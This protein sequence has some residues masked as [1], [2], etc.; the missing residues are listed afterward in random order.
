MKLLSL[1]ADKL[2]ISLS[3]LCVL[4][5]LALPLLLVIV[6]SLAVLPMAQESFHFWMVM[7]VLPT[8]IYALTLGC[9]KHRNYTVVSYGLAGLA[10]LLAAALFGEHLLGEMGEK[11]LTTVGATIIAV[12]HVK[13]FSLCRSHDKCACPS[14]QAS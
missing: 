8:S 1:Y 6:P 12:A 5:C 11:L 14:E 4:H 3:M 7:A 9:K 2:A 13:N 10:T